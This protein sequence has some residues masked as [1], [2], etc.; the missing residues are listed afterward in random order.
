MKTQP[1][2]VVSLSG[3]CADVVAIIAQHSLVN[4]AR[5]VEAVHA[6]LARWMT[7]HDTSFACLRLTRDKV[8]IYGPQR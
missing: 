6:R 5:T 2:F 4:A 8:L 7:L 1:C 3:M